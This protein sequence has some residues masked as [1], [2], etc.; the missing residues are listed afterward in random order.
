MKRVLFLCSRNKLRSPT[1][2]TVFANYTQLEVDSGGLSKDA[3]V[4]V[5]EDQIEWADIIF[6]MEKIHRERLNK[7]FGSLLANKRVTVLGIP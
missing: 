7:Q 6:V 3:A 5:S 1:A 4:C 2:E